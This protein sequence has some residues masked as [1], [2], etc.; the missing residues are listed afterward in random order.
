MILLKYVP[1]ESEDTLAL[2]LFGYIG[3]IALQIQND[4]ILNSELGNELWPSKS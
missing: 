2:G 1:N 4:I 3:D